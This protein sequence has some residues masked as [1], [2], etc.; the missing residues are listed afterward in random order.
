MNPEL[1]KMQ[2]KYEL[3]PFKAPEVLAFILSRFRGRGQE[4]VIRDCHFLDFYLP[5]GDVLKAL[6][7]LVDEGYLFGRCWVEGRDEEYLDIEREDY[8]LWKEKGTDIIHP[9]FGVPIVNPAEDVVIYWVPT[10]ILVEALNHVDPIEMTWQQITFSRNMQAFRSLNRIVKDD[11]T[12]DSEE[13]VYGIEPADLKKLQE[14]VKLMN[15][16]LLRYCR[17]EENGCQ[18]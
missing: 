17:M 9:E 6:W 15:D 14:L 4:L 7:K 1:E 11:L 18:D 16:K 5:W 3:S 10:E 2:Q 13:E 12:A 8:Q